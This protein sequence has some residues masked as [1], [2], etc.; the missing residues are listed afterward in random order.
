MRTS[1]NVNRPLQNRAAAITSPRARNAIAEGTT[2]N[3][4]C[5]KPVLRR[6]RTISAPVES[7]LSAPAIAGSSAAETDIPNRL[8]GSVYNNVA[9]DN[10]V[11]AP[12][13]SQL[14]INVSM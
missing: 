12:V 4:I 6:D 13:G 1:A 9:F 8:T 7:M 14:A 2:K 10:P 11:T 3:A 5:R